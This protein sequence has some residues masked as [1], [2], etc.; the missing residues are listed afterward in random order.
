MNTNAAVPVIFIGGAVTTG[1]TCQFRLLI[2]TRFRFS[3]LKWHCVDRAVVVLRQSR[4]VGVSRRYRNCQRNIDPG[5]HAE[6]NIADWQ[7]FKA[8]GGQKNW[9]LAKRL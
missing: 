2:F 7:L 9:N 4:H 3:E 5:C 6:R 8:A 1:G